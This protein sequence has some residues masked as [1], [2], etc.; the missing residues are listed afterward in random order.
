VA[1]AA[2]S[3]CATD[4]HYYM[5]EKRT[6]L[7]LRQSPTGRPAASAYCEWRVPGRQPTATPSNS[8]PQLHEAFSWLDR[9]F[10]ERSHWLVWLRL[11]PRWKNLR[12][13]PRFATLIEKIK[14]PM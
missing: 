14:Y 2:L 13:D 7:L 11:D 12:D 5:P 4:R 10:E 3:R 8:L 6:A 9:A 1:F